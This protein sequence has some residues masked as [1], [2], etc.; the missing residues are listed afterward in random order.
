LTPQEGSAIYVTEKAPRPAKFAVLLATLLALT[1]CSSAAKQSPPAP[2]ASKPAPRPAAPKQ[3][4]IVHPHNR[5]VPILMYHVVGTAPAGAPYPGLYVGRADFAGQLAWLRAHDYHAVSLL[6]VYDYWKHG[7]ALPRRPIVLTF[8]DGYR[9]DFTN[10]RPLL[11]RR[12]WPGVLNLAVRNLLDGKLTTP[13]IWLMIRQG[14]EVDA[15]T[16][17][18]LDLTT[19]GASQ[20]RHEVTGSRTWI[21]RRFH[22]PVDFFCYPSGRYDTRVLAAVRAAGFLAATIEGLG[23]ASPQ[24]GL[25]TLPRIRVDGSDGVSGLAAKL[26]AYG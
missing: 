3:P 5:P 12:H 4:Q 1:G 7:Y 22:V 25:L 15:H 17:N 21:R 16:I 23:P 18:H 10:V 9:E 19:L 20:L 26:G 2:Q 13:Q 8:D 24:D 14:W 6:R 11:A